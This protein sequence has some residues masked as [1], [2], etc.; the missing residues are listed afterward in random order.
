[1]TRYDDI[2]LCAQNILT[3]LGSIVLTQIGRLYVLTLRERER[4]FI[5]TF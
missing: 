4:I 2:G 3:I 1:M 5:S